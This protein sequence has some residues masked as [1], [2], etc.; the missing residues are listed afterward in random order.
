MNL[1]L[2]CALYSAFLRQFPAFPAISG[3]LSALR[4]PVSSCC[5]LLTSSEYLLFPGAAHRRLPKHFPLLQR[6]FMSGERNAPDLVL[7][8]LALPALKTRIDGLPRAERAGQLAPGGPSSHDPEHSLEDLAMFARGASCG[9][10]LRR[11]QGSDLV[12]ASR[13]QRRQPSNA[14]GSW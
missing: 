10:P 5:S 8:P 3:V 11:Q 7:E 14:N 9:R 13:C 2:I 4:S 12:P 6:Q 1:I